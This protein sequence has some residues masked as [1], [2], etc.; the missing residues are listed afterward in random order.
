M[1]AAAIIVFREVIEAGLIVGIVLAATRGVRT[2]TWYVFG[3]IGAGL[4]GAAL[5]AAFA[6]TLSSALE[7][8]G[9]EVFSA[10]IL[11]IAVVMLG[12][13][14]VWMAQHGR[15]LAAELTAAGQAVVSGAKTLT[16]LSI[17][18]AVAVLREGVE[19]VLFLYG[20]VIANGNSAWS[21]FAGGMLG[22]FAGAALSAL[23]YAGLL[24]IP[25]RYLFTVTSY[26]IAFLAAGMASQC[27]HFLDQADI[28]SALSTTAW[29]TSWLLSS[30][31]IAG[32][33]FHTLLGYDDR[34]SV[35]QVIVYLSTLITILVAMHVFEPGK[36]RPKRQETPAPAKPRAIA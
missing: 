9:Q 5:L 34:P 12:W 32:R 27:V 33:I 31:S 15:E 21:L 17:V 3:G 1:L 20:V 11:G 26:L 28:V 7:G 25:P 23:T 18:V 35:M 22:L 29:D 19:V 36:P 4:L 10:T 6:G 2:R 14:N 13:H 16:A 24:K 30:N 8:V